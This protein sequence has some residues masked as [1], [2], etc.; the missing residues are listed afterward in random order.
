MSAVVVYCPGL[1]VAVCV[2][3]VCE[4]Y[5]VVGHVCSCCLSKNRLHHCGDLVEVVSG[6]SGAQCGG[7]GGCVTRGISA[8]VMRHG[9]EVSECQC[10]RAS[11]ALERVVALWCTFDYCLVGKARL[12]KIL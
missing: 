11:W 3:S 8:E 12:S 9:G 5:E 6:Q 10:L 1:L 2:D 7:T 4:K